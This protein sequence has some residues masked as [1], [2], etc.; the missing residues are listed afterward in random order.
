MMYEFF[1]KRRLL[2]FSIITVIVL[3]A[4]FLASRLR[5]EEDITKMI[6]GVEN[7]ADITRIIEQSKILDRIV[8]NISLADTSAPSDTEELIRNAE[9]LADTLQQ[10]V[11][12]PYISNI[13]FRVSENIV[14]DVF[15]I[16]CRN[17]PVFLDESDYITLESMIT[18]EKMSESLANSYGTLLSPASFAMK[19]MIVRD[20]VGITGIA[21]KKFA[22][23][24]ND[25]TYL[26]IDGAVFS[27]NKKHLLMFLTTSFPSGATSKNTELVKQLDRVVKKIENDTNYQDKYRIFRICCCGCR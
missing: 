7:K 21:T 8:V 10:P 27:R 17:L 1:R 12:Q 9:R 6:S 11:F 5:F 26:I 20:P 13:T 16:V 14:N 23:F 2:F 19:K 24:Q 3:T 15:D 18:P 4:V 25:T 22:S